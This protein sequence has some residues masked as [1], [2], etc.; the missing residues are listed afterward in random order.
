MATPQWQQHLATKQIVKFRIISQG[1]NN[2]LYP[3]QYQLSLSQ[4]KLEHQNF[5]EVAGWNDWQEQMIKLQPIQGILEPVTLAGETDKSALMAHAPQTSLVK[6]KTPQQSFSFS[7]GIL[8][9]GVDQAIEKGE[10][11]GVEFQV[12]GIAPGGTEEILFSRL[13]Q[14]TINEQDRGIQ[15]AEIELSDYNAQQLTLQTIAMED[16]T[17]DWSYWTNLEAK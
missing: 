10:G 6:F 16:N 5:D 11:D 8:T 15:Q 1:L 7:F 12:L 14:P 4:L 13:L 2:W 9:E 3:H 17:W